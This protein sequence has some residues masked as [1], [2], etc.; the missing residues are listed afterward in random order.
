M[1]DL[2]TLSMEKMKQSEKKAFKG[3]MLYERS[4][5]VIDGKDEAV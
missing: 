2:K 4:Q 3:W 5:D 1:K